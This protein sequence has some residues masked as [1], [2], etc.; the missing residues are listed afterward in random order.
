MGPDKNNQIIGYLKRSYFALDGLWFLI[1]EEYLSLEEALKI[2]EQ[3][4]RIL[5]KIQAREVRKMLD[6]RGNTLPDFFKAIKVKLEAEGYRYQGR[7]EDESLTLSIIE[8]P[9]YKI[10]RK[11][12]REHLPLDDICRIDFQAWAKEFN[13]KIKVNINSSIC[14]R[15][16]SCEVQFLKR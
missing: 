16:T 4:W 12:K 11:S 8:C 1:V 5:P 15:A 9:W 10:I 3:V 6:I 2:D 13:S 14:K 7:L